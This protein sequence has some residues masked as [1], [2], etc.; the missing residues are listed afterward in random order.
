MILPRPHMRPAA[1][2]QGQDYKRE[3]PKTAARALRL[4]AA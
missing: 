1:A 2:L 3:I 4:G